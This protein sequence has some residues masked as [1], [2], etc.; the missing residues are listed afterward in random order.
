M[1]EKTETPK[2][3]KEEKQKKINGK[4]FG[5]ICGIAVV[6]IALIV[7]IGIYNTPINRLSRQLDLGNR[8][9]EEQNYEQAIVEFDKAIAIDPMSVD[10]YLGKAQA[11][12]GMGDIDMAIQTL[13]AGL[14]RT[15]D[16]QIKDR[17][18]EH[19]LKQAQEYTDA[20]DYGKALEIYDRFL[21]LDGENA[22]VQTDIANCLQEY[23]DL[24]ME[25]ERYDEAKA[26]IEKYQ[27]KVSGID[28]QAILDEIV[29]RTTDYVIEWE[30]AA[31]EAYIRELM[32]RPEG[33]IKRSDVSQIKVLEGI[34]QFYYVNGVV[35]NIQ[36]LNDL[37]HFTGLEELRMEYLNNLIEVSDISVV[38]SLS[39][40]VVLNLGFMQRE[41]TG[42]SAISNLTNLKSLSLYQADIG[43]ISMFGNLT[44]L[45]TLNLT[46]CNISDIGPLSNLTN[47][48][49]LELYAN[50]ISDLSPLRNLT[51]LTL[52]DIWG[53]NISDISALS[54]LTNL[55]E[56]WLNSNNISDVSALSNLTNI[57]FLLLDFNNID[58]ISALS[59]LTKV[60]KLDINHNNISDISALQ[61]MSNLEWL[62]FQDNNVSDISVL[63]N[64]SKLDLIFMYHNPVTDLSP[65][66]AVGYVYY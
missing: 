59:N 35:T 20:T 63:S 22:Q 10:A 42:I 33:D 45:E 9:L 44:G 54:G 29:M 7:G 24:L 49:E 21:E 41:I 19:Y 1:Q 27:D 25:Q 31:F 47:L 6:L 4:K 5:I 3:V 26:L 17:L 32:G 39:N 43:D 11:Y 16:V 28:F 62:N 50:N 8:Y 38:G 64:L 60:E 65:V 14:E 61:N 34:K 12:E 36:T 46:A 56:L 30:D 23:L 66:A 40:L 18:V 53:N 37:R 48:K 51:N 52:L 2:T 55:K 15:D 57:T 13:E 58:D